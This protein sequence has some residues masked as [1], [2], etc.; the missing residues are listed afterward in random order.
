MDDARNAGASTGNNAPSTGAR[1]DTVIGRRTAMSDY[2][3]EFSIRRLWIIFGVSMA[4]MFGALI[5][6]GAQIYHTRPPIP[7]AV[8][9]ASGQVL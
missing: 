5:Y 8:R 6:F 4:V 2:A 3:S 1:P 7:A 9:T